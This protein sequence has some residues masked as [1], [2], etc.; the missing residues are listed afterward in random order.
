MEKIA[1]EDFQ[2]IEAYTGTVLSASLN[3][4]ARVP[5]WVMEIDFGDILGTKKTSAQLTELYQSDELVGTQVVAIVN[6]PPLRIAG[7]KSEVL[8]LGVLDSDGVV[9]LRPD[10]KVDNGARI[11]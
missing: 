7:V 1:F 4:K 8:V 3:E 9:L 6:F 11:A 5:A 10:R 2:K